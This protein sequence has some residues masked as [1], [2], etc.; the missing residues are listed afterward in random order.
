MPNRRKYF[1]GASIPQAVLKAARH[2]GLD[3]DDVAWEKL[4]KKSGFVRGRRKVVIAIDPSSPRR[5]VVEEEVV[6]EPAPP[7][8]ELAPRPDSEIDKADSGPQI[9]DEVPGEASP[10]EELEIRDREDRDNLD[11]DEGVDIPDFH[12]LDE[13]PA[14][15]PVDSELE[16]AVWNAL[17]PLL[18]LADLEIEAEIGERNG[19]LSVELLGPDSALVVGHQG[20]VLDALGQLLPR[21]L[22]AERGE[23][24]ACRIDCESFWYKR[25]M[26]L[27]RMA[28]KEARRSLREERSRSLQPMNP[29]ERRIVHQAIADVDGVTTESR[30]DGR[31][32]R[33]VIRPI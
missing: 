1:S 32:K 23:R 5:E 13:A 11:K 28:I 22:S 27:C 19:E 25:E 4:E 6:I 16:D 21:L 33:V 10:R 31:R 17:E 14:L 29:R 12:E 7:E 30:G 8:L 20:E 9:E 26:E 15:E 24:V 2:F 3:P 18:R